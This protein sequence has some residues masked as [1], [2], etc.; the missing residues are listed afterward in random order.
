VIA[1]PE[2]FWEIQCT[3]SSI[4][5]KRLAAAPPEKVT[6]LREQFLERCREVQGRGGRL[7]YPFGAFFVAAERPEGNQ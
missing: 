7:V 6:S 2:E 4:A 3:F 1:T 5:R